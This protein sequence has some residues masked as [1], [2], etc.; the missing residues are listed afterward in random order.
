MVVTLV[1]PE[2][3]VTVAPEMIMI[4]STRSDGDS[5]NTRCNGDSM[6]MFVSL[7]A[8]RLRNL[9]YL[10]DESASKE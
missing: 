10:R 2:V 9:L 7:P 1:A 3:M 8:Q 5:S 4:S 6:R